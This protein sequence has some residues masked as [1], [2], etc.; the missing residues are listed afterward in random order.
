MRPF[1]ALIADTVG[2]LHLRILT[3]SKMT[4]GIVY[5]LAEDRCVSGLAVVKGAAIRPVADL[6]V[7]DILGAGVNSPRQS[8]GS[9]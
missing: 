7:A 3:P 2:M 4:D 1:E 6:V 5:V 9:A 8:H